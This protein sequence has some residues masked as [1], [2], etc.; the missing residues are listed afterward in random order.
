M[1][2]TSCP[3]CDLMS[4]QAFEKDDFAPTCNLTIETAGNHRDYQ[5]TLADLTFT[6]F[7]FSSIAEGWYTSLPPRLASSR[8]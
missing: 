8:C 1:T 7:L 4:L 6:F 3:D 5:L 2:V